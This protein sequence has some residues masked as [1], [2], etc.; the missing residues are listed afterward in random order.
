VD[1]CGCL[2]VCGA[3]EDVDDL[4]VPKH[5]AV[6]A[7]G[8]HALHR[9]QRRTGRPANNVA[10]AG[11]VTI[12]QGWDRIPSDQWRR[13]AFIDTTSSVASGRLRRGHAR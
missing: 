5:G 10:A 8:A 13:H 2:N 1:A 3:L 7:F 11:I 9:R 4:G 6:D 12:P